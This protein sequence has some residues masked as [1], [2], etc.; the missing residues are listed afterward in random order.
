MS[1]FNPRK[2]GKPMTADTPESMAKDKAEKEKRIVGKIIKVD[3][4]GW[5]FVISNELPFERIFL[6]WSSLL[7]ST[8]RFPKLERGMKVEFAARDQGDD[9]ITGAPKGYKAIRVMVIDQN[10]DTSDI[11]GLDDDAEAGVKS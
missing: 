7:Q 3:P 2:D 4:R 9:P 10:I 6:H 5:A 8:L 11:E 1:L